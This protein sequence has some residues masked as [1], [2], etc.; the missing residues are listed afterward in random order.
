MTQPKNQIKLYDILFEYKSIGSDMNVS[1]DAKK[2]A[3]IMDKAAIKLG[4][5]QPVITSGLRLSDRQIAA[6]FDVWKK[7]GSQ[8]LIKLYAVDCKSCNSKAGEIASKIADIWEK[9]TKLIPNK[10]LEFTPKTLAWSLI[11]K[12]KEILDQYP[13]G[14]STHQTGEALDYGLVSNAPDQINSLL[15][16]IRSNNLAEF[17]EINETKLDSEGNHRPGSHKHVTIHNITDK[18]KEF[19]KSNAD[20]LTE[21]PT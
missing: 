7:E 17:E 20:D 6:M 18:G 13:E 5:K 10:V 15:D 9:N 2:F 4:Y 14:I 19:L 11:A 21:D 1:D 3:D 16:Y 8:F 12:A